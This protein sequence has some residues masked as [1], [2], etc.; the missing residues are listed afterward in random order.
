MKLAF[1]CSGRPDNL[2]YLINNRT[3]V[4]KLLEKYG[5]EVINIALYSITD[6]NKRL[7]EYKNSKFS[8]NNVA[9]SAYSISNW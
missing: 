8:F 9:K 7:K 4:Y 1:V 6:L 3:M 2:K 5:W